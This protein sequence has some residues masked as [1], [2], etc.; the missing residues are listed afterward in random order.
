MPS[1]STNGH[2]VRN[3]RDP[4]TQVPGMRSYMHIPVAYTDTKCLELPPLPPFAR[5][6]RTYE[7]SR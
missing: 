5:S 4:L 3:I 2:A 7:V 6:N 1:I